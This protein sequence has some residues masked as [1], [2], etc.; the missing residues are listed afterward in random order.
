MTAEPASSLLGIERDEH[1]DLGER[2]EPLVE[3]DL[4]AL[5]Q[6]VGTGF[7]AGDFPDGEPGGKMPPSPEVTRCL[8]AEAVA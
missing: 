4:A 8:V 7:Q 5:E 2:A 1:G 6:A 3:L